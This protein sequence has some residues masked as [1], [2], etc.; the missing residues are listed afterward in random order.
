M[1]DLDKRL[2]E[3]ITALTEEKE[4]ELISKW[5]A[6]DTRKNISGH[7][8]TEEL[9]ELISAISKYERPGKSTAENWLN[10]AEELADVQIISKMIQKRYDIIDDLLAKIR[11]LKLTVS[12]PEDTPDKTEQTREQSM[13]GGRNDVNEVYSYKGMVDVLKEFR[14][15]VISTRGL[16]NTVIVNHET[17][18]PC[19]GREW[20]AMSVNERKDVLMTTLNYC[21]ATIL[22]ER[23][24][25]RIAGTIPPPFVTTDQNQ[26]VQQI[27][28]RA[29]EIIE[30][31]M[32]SNIDPYFWSFPKETLYAHCKVYWATGIEFL[33]NWRK[34]VLKCVDEICAHPILHENGRAF[35]VDETN[36]FG[37]PLEVPI[38]LYN[39]LSCLRMNN[40]AWLKNHN[41]GES[42]KDIRNQ[43]ISNPNMSVDAT[44]RIIDM[45]C[46]D[47]REINEILVD[48]IE[49]GI[50]NPKLSAILVYLNNL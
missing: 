8:F 25:R 2:R 9:G 33:A 36:I 10:I 19:T 27:S 43:L 18:E 30:L 12:I 31:I 34:C 47:F 41:L 21:E 14:S 17:G 39:I 7:V 26:S 37:D 45:I 23:K 13:S 16:F 42:V 24:L 5:L 6:Y 38:V 4:D 28:D 20:D 40:A 44:N 1:K 15:S 29:I 22:Y 32:G 46:Y 49:H 48:L 35:S 11:T 50:S 3:D